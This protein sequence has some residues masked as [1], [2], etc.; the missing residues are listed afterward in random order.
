MCMTYIHDHLVQTYGEETFCEFVV[1]IN[2]VLILIFDVLGTNVPMH[3]CQNVWEGFELVR[4]PYCVRIIIKI[5]YMHVA[6]G[7]VFITMQYTLFCRRW[8][9]W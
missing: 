7:N 1:V 8:G 5:T 4:Y 2:A 6:K 3:I 9:I